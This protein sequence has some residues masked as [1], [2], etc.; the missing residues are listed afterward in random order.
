MSESGLIFDIQR[1]SVHDG[2][3]IRTTVFFKGCS[4]RCFWCHNPEG[5]Q[6]RPQIQYLEN[7]CIHCGECVTTCLDEGQQLINGSHTYV[8]DLCK[9]CGTCIEVCYADALQWVGRKASVEEVMAEVMADCVFYE[10]S[11][12]GVTLSGGD[13][14]LQPDFAKA[15]LVACRANGVHSAIETAGNVTWKILGEIISLVDLVMMDLKHM[16][17]ERHRAV[18]GV[19]NVKIL[20]NARKISDSGKPV[21]FRTPI[22]PGVNDS[23]E[24]IGEIGKFINSLSN[25]RHGSGSRT[26][27]II[28]ELLAFHRL[29]ADKYR[30]LGLKYKA[31]ELTLQS[32]EEFGQLVKVAQESGVTVKYPE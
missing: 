12:G 13:P 24:E 19:S 7:R 14:V 23:Q 10:T 18:T 27:P 31:Q 29:A 9:Q 25:H 32:K 4:L 20:E 21:I 3:G 1:F 11:G 22:V 17:P 6:P 28:W 26:A 5:I 16:N 2:P 15:L 30:S 8:R